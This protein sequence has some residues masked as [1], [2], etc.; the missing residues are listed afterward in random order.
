MVDEAKDIILQLKNRCIGEGIWGR[1]IQPILGWNR[2][3][4]KGI[5]GGIGKAETS[6]GRKLFNHQCMWRHRFLRQFFNSIRYT[7]F[8][9][10]SRL[11]NE[12][13]MIQRAYF[14]SSINP[15]LLHAIKE[16]SEEDTL[17]YRE[18]GLMEHLNTEFKVLYPLFVRRMKLMRLRQDG[19][20]PQ[21]Y[22]QHINR[23]SLEAKF[24]SLD[25]QSFCILHLTKMIEDDHLW[26]K[27]FELWDPT[28]RQ[29]L[30]LVTSCV[31][32]QRSTKA[33]KDNEGCMAMFKNK[34]DPV[35]DKTHKCM[36]CGKT[37]HWTRSDQCKVLEKGLCCSNCTK[38]GHLASVCLSKAKPIRAF[39]PENEDNTI[40]KAYYLRSINPALLR[41]IKEG[42]EE[43]T[44]RSEKRGFVPRRKSCWRSRT[45]WYPMTHDLH[46]VGLIFYYSYRFFLLYIHI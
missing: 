28:Y 33:T 12:D 3:H 45:Y 32:N 29:M 1:H 21:T 10:K 42:S 31:A 40:Q 43:D 8:F 20:N 39:L 15:A 16:G 6:Q 18:G 35:K 34:K 17:V 36:C 19:E 22:L 4:P 23:L 9:K 27:I 46:V 2:C 37:N 30:N 26:E 44:L 38:K 14:S 25:R 11:E 41:A 7:N 5:P 24:E 13:N